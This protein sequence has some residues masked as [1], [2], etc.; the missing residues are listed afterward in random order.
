[1]IKTQFLP[2]D[3]KSR[4]C[5]YIPKC[6]SAHTSMFTGFAYKLLFIVTALCGATTQPYAQQL[7]IQ[8]DSI[9]VRLHD[10]HEKG[11]YWPQYANVRWLPD[12]SGYT[13]TRDTVQFK[14]DILSGDETKM[15]EE[16]IKALEKNRKLSPNQTMEYEYRDGNLFVRPASG[17]D[18]YQVTNNERPDEVYHWGFSWSPDGQ[19]LAFVEQDKAEVRV[20]TDLLGDE[21][22]YPSLRKQHFPRVGGKIAKYRVGIAHVNSNELKWA[23]LD[24]PEEGF[25]LGQVE[26]SNDELTIEYLS[27]FRDHRKILLANPEN[28][29]VHS[30]FEE[31]DP[32]WVMASYQVNSGVEWFDDGNRFLIIHERDGWRHAYV[33]SRD[34]KQLVK[35]TK[36]DFDI[37]R[38]H[39][40]DEDNGWFY[41]YASP[42]NATQR[43]L[44]RVPLDGSK[45]SER[46]TP[47]NQTGWHTYVF[48]P[49]YRCAF[50]INDAFDQPHV[51]KLIEWPSHRTIRV[52]EDNAALVKKM[53]QDGFRKT[54]FH[55]VNIGN[56][57][58]LDAWL[59]KPP[60]FDPS[61]KYPVLVYVYSEPHAQTVLDNYYQSSGFHRII[62]DLGYIVLSIDS[63][64][65]PVPKGAAWRRAVFGSLGPLSTKE[66]AA[67]LRALGRQHSYID[68]SRVGIWGWSGG[69][70]NTLNAMFRE[71]DLYKVGIAVASKPQPW[72]YNAWFQEMYMRTREVNPEGYEQSAPI[73]FAEG[74][75]GDLLIIH[76]SGEDNTHI[77][78]VEGLVD[79]LIE[80]GKRFDYMVY[81]HRSHGI[82]EGDGT[83]VHLRSL[84]TRYLLEHLE[85]GAK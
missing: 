57:V 67:A 19:Y 54:E 61:K 80:L 26:W 60:N 39:S 83:T 1:M 6:N 66:Q 3:Y 45:A 74:L 40:I 31:S 25:Y 10:V 18:E 59:M 24:S 29:E 23:Q 11:I 47:D 14:V 9:E 34:G 53:E 64:G 27:R 58:T 2:E 43:F 70:S 78:I 44:Y 82:S 17:D 65:T 12:G 42:E 33:H 69:G 79:R 8:L 4:L 46:V 52:L 84:M 75:K 36:G 38:R 77:Q 81:P 32:A 76:G 51:N 63:R 48:A 49:G 37:I 28:G 7:Q 22:T 50:H 15:N 21:P 68:L 13:I 85:P 73:N 35:L 56:D 55:E 5:M 41:F 30:V 71:P 20:R 16:E 62:S 72:L